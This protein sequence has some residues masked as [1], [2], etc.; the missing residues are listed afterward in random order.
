MRGQ[1]KLYLYCHGDPVNYL[2]PWGLGADGLLQQLWG[3]WWGLIRPEVGYWVLEVDI[4]V[5][6]FGGV[7]V[8]FAATEEGLLVG[9][10]VFVG[11]FGVSLTRG[12]G[13]MQPHTITE[14]WQW[15]PGLAFEWGAAYEEPDVW[16]QM[17]AH[18][19][20]DQLERYAELGIA[21]P[22]ISYNWMH[23]YPWFED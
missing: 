7:S 16:E 20:G 18:Y 19:Q 14:S 15:S 1:V 13:E 9:R 8:G 4:P 5:V 2:D 10:G 6:F 3:W 12:W 11:S 22:G 17:S 21:T 23:W